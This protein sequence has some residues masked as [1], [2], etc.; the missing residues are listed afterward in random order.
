NTMQKALNPVIAKSEGAGDRATMLRASML[1][2][3]ISFFLL[4]VFYVP[5]LIEM[6]YIFKIWLKDVPEFAVVFCRLLLLRNMVEQFYSTLS[7][8]IAAVGNIKQFQ[9]Y[10]SVL[11]ILPLLVSYLLFA[12]HYPPYALYLTFL[13]F[14]FLSF[15]ATVY[16]ANKN[17]NLNTPYYMK[18]IVLRCLASFVAIFL[19][20]VLPL[21]FMDS[22]IPRLI[23]VGGTSLFAFALAVWKVGFTTGEQQRAKHLTRVLYGKFRLILLLSPKPVNNEPA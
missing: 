14:S 2:S 13:L 1:G 21:F 5:V 12:F 16:F 3:K 7:N 8:S 20:S 6:P 9:I 10:S 18:H 4:V 17:C 15:G 11:F 23:L 19:V 22:G